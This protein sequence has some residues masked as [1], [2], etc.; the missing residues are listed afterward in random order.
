MNYSI[1][2]FTLLSQY[3]FLLSKRQANQ[4]IWGWFINSRGLPAHNISCDLFIEHLNRV[5]KEAING[6]KANKTPKALVR[7]SKVVG[8]LDDVI[9][10]FNEDNSIGKTSGRH[11]YASHRKDVKTV[12][13]VLQHEKA[14]KYSSQRFHP[15]FPNVVRNRMQFINNEQLLSWMYVQ[16][17]SLVHGF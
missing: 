13:N 7:V 6:L 14:F 3:H 12:V 1:E 2:A 4:F 16:L 5:C 8:K 10:N 11:K 15:S 17:N 9:K